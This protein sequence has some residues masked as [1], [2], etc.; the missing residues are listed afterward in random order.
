MRDRERGPRPWYGPD[1]RKL[2]AAAL[3]AF[4]YCQQCGSPGPLEVDH[5]D[6]RSLAAGVRVL[7]RA[8]HGR[9]TAADRKRARPGG[10]P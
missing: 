4:P 1:W 8:C 10:R 3:A 5:V 9:K 7:C 6:P 2:R